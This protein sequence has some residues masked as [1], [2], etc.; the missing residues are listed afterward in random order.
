MTRKKLLFITI[1]AGLVILL[2]F[3]G[4]SNAI[5]FKVMSYEPKGTTQP[6]LVVAINF[7]KNISSKTKGT[8]KLSPAISGTSKIKDSHLYFYLG[9]GLIDKQTYTVTVS[10]YTSVD[11][12]KMK[13]LK[14][15][16]LVDKSIK[17]TPSK[18]QIDA[19]IAGTDPNSQNPILNKLPYD[20]LT[21]RITG[22]VNGDV[23]D[24]KTWRDFK[25]NYFIKVQ[26]FA[27]KDPK[28]LENFKPDTLRLRQ[29]ALDW[30]KQQGVDP[31]KDIRIFYTPDD[32]AIGVSSSKINDE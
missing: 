12:K 5:N 10:G 25:D 22:V 31:A 6:P 29:Q 24:A 3:I 2:I 14:F 15:T 21:F 4:I 26:T 30:I 18:A 28:H 11:N 1:G 17:Q 23:G 9:T 7:N 32:Q 16:F 20:N 13:D 8:V 27:Y 19:S